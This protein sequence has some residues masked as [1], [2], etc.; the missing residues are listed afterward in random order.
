LHSI[1][2]AA[3]AAQCLQDEQGNRSQQKEVQSTS[4]RIPHYHTRD[5]ASQ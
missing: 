5:P 1:L 4:E 2:H 3:T